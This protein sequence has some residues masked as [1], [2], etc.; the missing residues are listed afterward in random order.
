[1]KFQLIRKHS[2]TWLL[3][4]SALFAALACVSQI[5]TNSINK[6][7]AT[8]VVSLVIAVLG[9]AYFFQTEHR[10]QTQLFHQLFKEFNER[11]DKLNAKLNALRQTAE[12]PLNQEAQNTL[13]DYFNL[14]AEEYLYYRA[15]YI[16]L[17]VWECWKAGMRTFLKNT[18]I[19]A[20]LDA[21]LRTGSY[22]GLNLTEI[23]TVSH[24]RGLCLFSRPPGKPYAQPLNDSN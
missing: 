9:L 6:E 20:L 5:L 13:Y 8:V 15:G 17:I 14:C 18:A 19:R 22:Y 24:P 23:E 7:L 12:Q 4:A 16:D 2:F 3:I 11:Y 21:E 10:A 1:M